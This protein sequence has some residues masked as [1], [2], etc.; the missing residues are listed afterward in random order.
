MSEAVI[1]PA[2][3]SA[4]LVEFENEISLEVNSRV[5][6]LKYTLEQSPFEG[7]GELVPAY[8]SLLIGYDPLKIR[9]K[10]AQEEILT[11]H[12]KPILLLN[13][14]LFSSISEI[15]SF[16]FSC[17]NVSL[18]GEKAHSP[19]VCKPKK[20]CEERIIIFCTKTSIELKIL[21]LFDTI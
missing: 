6:A 13:V 8:R 7:M 5:R 17:A 12:Q 9:M 21:C 15:L 14:S 16:L 3:D 19:C 18:R 20:N 10:A 4:L 11:G 2:G 1:R